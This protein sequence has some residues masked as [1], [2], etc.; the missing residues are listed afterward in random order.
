MKTCLLEMS[1]FIEIN[2]FGLRKFSKMSFALNIFVVIPVQEMVKY[3]SKKSPQWTFLC[4]EPSI[5][6]VSEKM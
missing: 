5:K 6:N 4:R 2:T 3:Y 1:V